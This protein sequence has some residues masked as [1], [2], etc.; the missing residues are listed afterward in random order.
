MLLSTTNKSY[1]SFFLVRG[2][3]FLL[4]RSSNIKFP[5]TPKLI[6][7]ITFYSPLLVSIIIL[8]LNTGA[9]LAKLICY[10]SLQAVKL[11]SP[12]IPLTRRFYRFPKSFLTCYNYTDRVS[13][14]G[15]RNVG[16]IS[17]STRA[18]YKLYS[19]GIYKYYYNRFLQ[20]QEFVVLVS[21]DIIRLRLS[22]RRGPNNR[23]RSKLSSSGIYIFV[24][25]TPR[26]FRSN[27]IYS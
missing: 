15:F 17:S 4:A 2:N 7:T 8:I 19:L 26:T 11:Y 20:P 23:Y 5:V 21:K 14:K 6:I 16:F 1:R 22:L 27:R 9:Q 10:F 12:S 18:Y 13:N 3:P 24:P 25:Y